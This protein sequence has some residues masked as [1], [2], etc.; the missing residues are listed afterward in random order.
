MYYY[1][2]IITI[3]TYSN[4]I[5]HILFVL[6]ILLF[7]RDVMLY[8]ILCKMFILIIITFKSNSFIVLIL[9]NY[10]LYLR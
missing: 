6:D 4:C 9:C 1:S 7:I 5:L 8:F 3:T 10:Q 2:T